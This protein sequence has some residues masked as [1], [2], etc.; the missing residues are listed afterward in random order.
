MHV[1]YQVPYGTAINLFT[2]TFVSYQVENINL[3][4]EDDSLNTS[5]V[6]EIAPNTSN[7]VCCNVE[8]NCLKFLV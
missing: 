6:L 7:S 1:Y 3:I 4:K 5:V 8:Y 2:E